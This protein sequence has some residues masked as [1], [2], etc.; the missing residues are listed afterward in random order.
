L[1]GAGVLSC[2]EGALRAPPPPPPPPPPL[3]RYP[4]DSKL[5]AELTVMFWPNVPPV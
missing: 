1:G 5:Q 2:G 3:L 4:R